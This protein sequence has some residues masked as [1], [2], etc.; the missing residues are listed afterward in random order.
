METLAKGIYLKKPLILKLA[1]LWCFTCS[2]ILALGYLIF[3]LNLNL[4]FVK[5]LLIITL[6]GLVFRLKAKTSPVVVFSLCFFIYLFTVY[7]FSDAP[8]IAKAASIRQ[9]IMPLIL[10]FFGISLG[11]NVNFKDSLRFAIKIGLFVLLVGFI[12]VLLGIWHY[13]NVTGY[14]KVKNIP[15]YNLSYP[16][17]YLYP[18]FFIEP[19][20]G[21]IK[22]MASTLLDPINLGHSFAFLF[23]FIYFK[24]DLFNSKNKRNWLAALFIL[25]ILMTFSKGAILQLI[26]TILLFTKKISKGI[27]ICLL[28]LFSIFLLY[29][30]KFHA[31]VMKHVEGLQSTIANVNF[32]GHGLAKTGNQAFMFGDPSVVIGDT[33]IGAI[34]GQI[35][36]LGFL[37]WISP[38]IVI[39]RRL[40]FNL[41]SKILIAQLIIALISENAFNLLSVFL[42]CIFIGIEYKQKIVVS[43]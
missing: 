41:T 18:V 20:F 29:A 7:F 35:G 43:K 33:Y 22:R 23:S 39:L 37:L 8:L 28:F 30:S 17:L 34:V 36:I 38:F 26:I 42:V 2:I 40:N 15:F 19:I 9:M 4:L 25:G 1:I 5:D 10:V 21:G 12:E 6:F 14:F 16:Q 27:K 3:D 32:F 24:K 31:G 11:N 13:I